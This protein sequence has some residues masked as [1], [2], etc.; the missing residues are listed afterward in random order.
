[1]CEEVHFCK[2]AGLQAYSWQLYYQINSFT[3]IFQQH[4]KSPLPCCPMYWLKP[5]PIKFWRAPCSQHLWETPN[6]GV[7]MSKKIYLW[8]PKF[9]GVRGW[10]GAI[11]FH[12]SK[13]CWGKYF[14]EYKKNI[15]LCL[16]SVDNEDIVQVCNN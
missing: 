7:D 13:T 5:C 12:I 9:K 2:F 8:G 4:F 10:G 3:G 14:I 15:L 16:G 1:M 6:L 11:T